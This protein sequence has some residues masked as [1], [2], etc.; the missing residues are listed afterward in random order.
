MAM[1]RVRRETTL[2]RPDHRRHERVKQL[3]YSISLR[4]A[5]LNQ[6]S[7]SLLR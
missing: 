5:Q 6:N 1:P 2:S 3:N 4:S 7:P